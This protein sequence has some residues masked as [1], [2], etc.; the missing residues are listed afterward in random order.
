MSNCPCS[1]RICASPNERLTSNPLFRRSVWQTAWNII[2]GSFRA[3]RSSA[4]QSRVPLS[5]TRRFWWRM[6]RPATWT[7]TLRKKSCSCLHSSIASFTRRSSWSRTTPARSDSST[8]FI[9]STRV[10]LSARRRAGC[11]PHRGSRCNHL[12]RRGGNMTK[13]TRLMFKNLL[14]SSRRTVLTVLSIAV[15][16]FIFAVLVSLPTFANQM[17]ADTTS[18]VR[19]VSR[20]KMGFAY[21]LPEAYKLKIATISHVVAVAPLVIY[22]GI[23]HEASD[24][25]PSVATEAEE[26]DMW[27][28]WGLTGV[29]E[30]Q[31][32]KN[33]CLVAQGTMRRF[34]LHVGQQIE[35][36]GTVY[37]F[38]VTL[39]IVGTI[40]KGPVPSF[41]IFRRDYFEEAAG[42]PGIAHEFWVRV[43]DSRV[44]PEV[45]AAID[46]QFANSPAE[47][48]SAS[49][50]AAI[51][52]ILGRYRIFM[53]L[54]ECLGLVAVVAIGL[55]AA[56][57][58][59]MS[60]RERRGEIAVMRSIGF[61][62][63]VILRLL[64]GESLI[65]ALSGGA[66]GCGV[67]VGLFKVFAF[68]ADA[69]GPFVSLHVPLFVLAE[70]LG[71]AALIGVLSAYVPARAAAKRSIVETLRLED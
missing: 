15:S 21:P 69:L 12:S 45:C 38:N 27:S 14:R 49:E 17:L 16:L 29:D 26:I 52:S 66:I 60:I 3:G 39:T 44:V 8:P 10:Y 68:N 20:T 43:D 70:T 32:I 1:S 48:R 59:A 57:T 37:P 5:P 40:A 42:K 46:H 24:Q 41:L 11:R 9:V 2:R 53:T 50:A 22:G 13:F 18:S 58:A 47:T 31:K 67:A 55:V 65:V 61:P 30:F 51:G 56:N 7:P 4:S 36:R 23:F 28:D 25:F 34:N 54:A 19:I 62:S 64:V 35:L 6:N 33:A 63:G 71:A